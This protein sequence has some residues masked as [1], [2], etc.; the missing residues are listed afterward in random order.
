MLSLIL[1]IFKIYKNLKQLVI[2]N[3]SIFSKLFLI[4]KLAKTKSINNN[5]LF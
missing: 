3:I 4:E 5:L 1:D 2:N